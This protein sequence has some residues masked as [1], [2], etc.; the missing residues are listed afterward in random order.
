MRLALPQIQKALPLLA[1]QVLGSKA[2]AI[3]A[4]THSILSFLIIHLPRRTR[5]VRKSE[6]HPFT[7]IKAEAMRVVHSWARTTAHLAAFGLPSTGVFLIPR[8][9]TFL[10]FQMD[11]P[12]PNVSSNLII[13]DWHITSLQIS[14]MLWAPRQSLTAEL[15]CRWCSQLFRAHSSTWQLTQ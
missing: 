1:S 8:C 15:G 12:D 10:S 11:T 14:M 13:A 2:H 4:S 7:S 6:V 9:I 3:M 5:R